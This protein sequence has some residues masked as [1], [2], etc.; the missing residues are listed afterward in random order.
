MHPRA[1]ITPCDGKKTAAST[2][3]GETCL[4]NP[5]STFFF[6]SSPG[7]YKVSRGRATPEIGQE[8]LQTI[9]CGHK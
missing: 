2:A 7:I 6:S 1:Q 4:M 8:Q 5:F 9:C 3:S